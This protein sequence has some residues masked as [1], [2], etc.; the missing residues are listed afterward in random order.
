V[1][2]HTPT[3]LVIAGYDPY[4]GAGVLADTKTVHAMGGYA[5]AVPTAMTV[6]N[7]QGVARTQ[8]QEP[9]MLEAQL[10]A[11]LDDLRIDTVKIGMLANR[12]V[13]EMVAA[14]IKRYDLDSVVL[15]PVM[16]SSSGRRLLESEAVA[17]MVEVL[18]PLARLITPNLDEVSTLLGTRFS[19]HDDEIEAMA[20]GLT[21]LGAKGI[22]LTG[23]H[24]AGTEAIDVLIEHGNITRYHAP[25]IE[26]THTHGTG[27][28]L[29]SA[30]ATAL[31]AQ[32]DMPTAI[33]KAKAFL[34]QYL[35][36]A[37]HLRLTYTYPH[38]NRR[39]PIL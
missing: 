35:Q 28:V 38:P 5:V 21:Q 22:L 1:K 25:K 4:G 23:G 11:L 37:E 30:I 19:G 3:V 31:A 9:A 26:T 36:H 32:T 10:C 14:I 18:F 13:V 8:P 17:T 6:Q 27:C 33:T 7:S 39:E 29:S 2:E 12:A 16:V 24:F 34:H 20:T 15:D